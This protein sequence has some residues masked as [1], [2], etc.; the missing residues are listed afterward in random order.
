MAQAAQDP[1]PA[2]PAGDGAEQPEGKT[3][4]IEFVGP[5]PPQFPFR[6]DFSAPP[7]PPSLIELSPATFSEATQRRLDRLLRAEMARYPSGTLGVVS[8]IYVGGTL[9]YNACPAGAFQFVGLV[10][11]AAGEADAGT[12][13]DRHVV[14]GLHHELSHALMDAHRATFDAARFREAL[15]SGFDYTDDRP[16]AVEEK[17]YGPGDDSPSLDLLDEGFLVPWARRSMDEDFSSYAEVLLRKPGLLLKTF[18]P[19]SRVGRKARVVRDFYIAI[20]KRFE[21][22]FAA[23]GR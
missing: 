7:D 10:F 9:T 17:A 3:P 19:D 2:P 5:R 6:M 8:E 4:T 15:P 12:V 18:A 20:D 16:G 11:I 14:R 23:D 13:T 21:G 22:V 1:R